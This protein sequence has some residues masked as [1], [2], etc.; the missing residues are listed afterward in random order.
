MQFRIFPGFIMVDD[1][2]VPND[3]GCG[4]DDCGP[5]LQDFRLHRQKNGVL[6]AR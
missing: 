4:F 3:A 1:F 2:E 5:T 6:Y